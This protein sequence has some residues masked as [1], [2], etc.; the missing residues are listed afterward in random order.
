MALL[1]LVALLTLPSIAL[2]VSV[3]ADLP[4]QEEPTNFTA[5]LDGNQE[6]PPRET[7]ATQR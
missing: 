3:S 7:E 1:T 2:M 5:Q 6:V 4:A